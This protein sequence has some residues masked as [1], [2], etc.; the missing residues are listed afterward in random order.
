[1]TRRCSAGGSTARGVAGAC[2][3]TPPDAASVLTGLPDA[4]VP[5]LAAA[6]A[7]RPLPGVNGEASRRAGVRRRRAAAPAT[8]RRRERL[9]RL[10]YARAAATRRRRAAPCL[11][12]TLRASCWSSGW[13]AFQTEI[14]ESPDDRR[15]DVE[16]RLDGLRVWVRDGEPVSLAAVSAPAGAGWRASGP[17]TRR[18][19]A[20]RAAMAA[21]LTAAVAGTRWTPAPRPCCCSRTSR[22]PVSNRIYRRL[23]FE[24]LQERLVLDFH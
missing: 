14:G 22:T 3:Q 10:G 24:P 8:L 6:L 11:R 4:A 20:R 9:Y 12:R 17:S 1:M 13:A 5:A 16:N 23:G 21:R 18:R 2:L 19:A 7:D 15:E